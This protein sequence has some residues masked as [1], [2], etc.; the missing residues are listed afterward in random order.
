MPVTF[1]GESP[2]YRA[3]RDRLL[4]MELELRRS[5]EAVA[6]ARRALPPGG[7]VPDG[8]AF[9]GL[10]AGRAAKQFS[11]ADLF[12]G[13]GTLAV[14]SYMFG[15]ERSEPCPMCTH[16]LD[17]LDAAA[18]H[19]GQRL[20]LCVVAESPLPRLLAFAEQR[21][22]RRLRLLS[23]AGSPYNRDYHGKTARGNDSVMLNVFRRDGDEVRHFWGSEVFYAKS[24]PGQDD[25]GLDMIS[26]VFNMLDL[27]PEGRGDFY[28][29]LRYA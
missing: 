6:R 22:W 29:E 16:L 19:L 13:Q 14:Y 5:T 23:A 9:E 26:T 10:G 12:A 27:T 3:A 7:V 18:E 24:D 8:Y 2:E 1:P 25:R 11:L 20:S 17:G 4:Q 15:P 28:T 21:G